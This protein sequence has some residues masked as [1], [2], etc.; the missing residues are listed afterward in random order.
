V[1]RYVTGDELRV[2][3]SYLMSCT[4]TNFIQSKPSPFL[5]QA[6]QR[7]Q[8]RKAERT[9]GYNQSEDRERKTRD[10]YSLNMG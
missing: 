4:T 10:T 6:R 1:R 3:T 2:T 9:E 5:Y 7:E 8:E